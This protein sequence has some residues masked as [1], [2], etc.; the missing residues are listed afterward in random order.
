M[1]TVKKGGLHANGILPIFYP[2]MRALRNIA[3]LF[4]LMLFSLGS[5][6][7]IGE[8]YDLKQQRAEL[9]SELEQLTADS[10]RSNAITGFR[11]R[12]INEQIMALDAEIFKSYDETVERV[13]AQQDESKSQGKMAVVLALIVSII[14]VFIVLLLFVARNKILRNGSGGFRQLYRE[15]T[16]DFIQQSSPEKPLSERLVRVN[17]VVVIGLVMMSVS[18]IAYLLTAL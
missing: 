3:L 15:L 14:G 12:E 13:T 7:D 5:M 18:V 2:K 10:T 8:T 6:A 16:L 11:I 4:A 17:V 9:V 1:L